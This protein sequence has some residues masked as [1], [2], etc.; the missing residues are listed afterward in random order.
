MTRLNKYEQNGVDGFF[1]H[2]GFTFLDFLVKT[3][4]SS[5]SYMSLSKVIISA[6]ELHMP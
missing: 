1:S 4:T 2:D 3:V 5:H 6:Y